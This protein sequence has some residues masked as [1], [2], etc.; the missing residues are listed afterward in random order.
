MTNAPT[1]PL[2]SREQ[3]QINFI[4]LYQIKGGLSMYE[5]KEVYKCAYCSDSICH[6]EEYTILNYKE[7][8][9][10]CLLWEMSTEELLEALEIYPTYKEA[11]Y[12]DVLAEQGDYEYE[13]FADK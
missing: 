13:C 5:G 10:D 12:E 1:K 9:K 2:T 6:G 3:K 7:Y 11:D 8:H 4:R